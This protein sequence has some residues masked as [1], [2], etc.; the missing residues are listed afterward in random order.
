VARVSLPPAGII[1]S[2]SIAPLA[3]YNR[4]MST[5]APTAKIRH[6]FVD[7]VRGIS[8]FGI[9]LVNAPFLAI[10]LEGAPPASEQEGL[11]RV[12]GFA[13]EAL[14]GGKFYLLFSFLFGYSISR[15]IKPEL[16]EGRRRY[17]R[18]LFGLAVLGA[19]HAVLLFIGDI[20]FTY[21]L[22]GCVLLFFV[23][24]SDRTVSI[25]A[26]VSALIALVIL[27]L[28]ALTP[29]DAEMPDSPAWT[30]L[31]EALRSGTFIEVSLA[32]LNVWPMVLLFLGILNY[33]LALSMMALGIIA[34]R[35]RLLDDPGSHRRLWLRCRWVGLLAGLPLGVLAASYSDHLWAVAICFGSAPLLSAGYL[36]LLAWIAERSPGAL[37]ICESAGRM[38]LTCYIM[39]SVLLSTIY[40]GYG[41]GF[42]GTHSLAQVTLVALGSAALTE[43]ASKIWLKRRSAGPMEMLMAWWCR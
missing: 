38:S 30:G 40:C 28:L 37:S 42:F 17:M 14:A 20:L 3:Q 16:P 24:R 15:F 11:S 31:N 43:A 29:A 1:E 25:L 39:E 8:L 34:G 26:G 23:R 6:A 22:L 36:G 10:G 4:G 7:Q 5:D 13:V 27:G 35:R 18:R 2:L 12:V 21:A 33:G 19:M 32:R 41:L 9:V